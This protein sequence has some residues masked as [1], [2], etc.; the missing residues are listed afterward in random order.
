MAAA[1]P[2]DPVPAEQRLDIVHIVYRPAAG[3]IANSDA[4]FSRASIAER[5]AAGYRDMQ[6]ALAAEPWLRIQQP[7]HLGA[8]VHP[9]EHQAV[10]TRPVPNLRTLTDR[11]QV[12]PAPTIPH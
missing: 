12:E 10:M 2:A 4:E 7:A 1:L 5:R 6:A 11:P 3:Q 8:L 9:A